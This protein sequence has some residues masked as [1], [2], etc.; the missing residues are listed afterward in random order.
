MEGSMWSRK[1]DD[2]VHLRRILSSF[3]LFSFSLF[4]F[5]VQFK[6]YVF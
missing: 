2:E 4:N 3:S 5:Y 6:Q 1:K